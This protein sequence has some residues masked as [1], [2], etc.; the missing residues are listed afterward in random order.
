[1]LADLAA[2]HCHRGPR[3][4]RVPA[5]RLHAGQPQ[6]RRSRG[7]TFGAAVEQPQQAPGDARTRSLL[8]VN[9]LS[10][11]FKSKTGWSQVIDNVSF[12]VAKG[13]VLGLV[14]ESGSGKTVSS[15]AILK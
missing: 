2:R 12:D 9:D 8:E 7:M 3:V 10:V 4:P 13:E 5:R 15:L 6:D 11:E 1:E 14:G